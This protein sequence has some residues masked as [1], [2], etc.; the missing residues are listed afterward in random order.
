MELETCCFAASAFRNI[1]GIVDDSFCSKLIIK[2]VL[3]IEG[4]IKSGRYLFLTGLTCEPELWFAE[5]VL[6]LKRVHTEKDLRLHV[7]RSSPKQ[8]TFAQEYLALFDRILQQAD[9]IIELLP[10]QDTD[11]EQIRMQYILSQA[12]HMICISNGKNKP[13]N[14][15]IECACSRGLTV[16]IIQLG[17]INKSEITVR[18]LT[19]MR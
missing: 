6:D 19:I 14:D 13:I 1:S 11:D 3:E 9:S 16:S 10:Q 2:I 17:R 18:N 12:K 15:L 4:Q 7:V 5:A 8:G